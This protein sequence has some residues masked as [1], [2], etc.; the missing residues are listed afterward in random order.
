MGDVGTTHTQ[1]RLRG[2]CAGADDHLPTRVEVLLQCGVQDGVCHSMQQGPAEVRY[3]LGWSQ[4]AF[5]DELIVA[6]Q[7]REEV[8]YSRHCVALGDHIRQREASSGTGTDQRVQVRSLV[9]H[10]A[11]HGTSGV[12][13]QNGRS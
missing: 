8:G 13:V 1:E 4:P 3:H 7:L 5:V 10:L 12:K 11:C 9:S 2:R 6:R